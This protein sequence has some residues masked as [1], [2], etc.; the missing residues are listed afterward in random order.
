MHSAVI[1][2][3]EV[4][5]GE[6]AAD[7]AG[8]VFLKLGFNPFGHDGEAQHVRILVTPVATIRPGQGVVHSVDSAGR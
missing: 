4:A 3:E 7:D 2:C 1:G 8:L 6:V 5:L